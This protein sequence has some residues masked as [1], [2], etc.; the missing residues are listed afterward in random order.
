VAASPAQPA[1][2][3]DTRIT[4]PARTRRCMGHRL[5]PIGGGAAQRDRRR[6]AIAIPSAALTIAA[7]G[8]W[9]IDSPDDPAPPG[10]DHCTTVEL[11]PPERPPRSPAYGRPVRYADD[12]LAV[13][14]T[15]GQAEAAPGQARNP[16]QPSGPCQASEDADCANSSKPPGSTSS[17]FTI[18]SCAK[19]TSRHWRTRVPRPLRSQQALQHTRERIRFL[20]MPRRRLTALNGSK[21][22]RTRALL[23]G[24]H[25]HRSAGRQTAPAK[26]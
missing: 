16:A 22:S 9:S 17:V 5:P 25:P 18:G 3:N 26:S 4:G 8:R 13:C 20:T 11:C 12:V 6:A 10:V 23:P 14:R 24:E 19:T 21:S 7:V 2:S 15:H 1:T